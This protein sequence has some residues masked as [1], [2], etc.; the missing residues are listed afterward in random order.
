MSYE[1]INKL[2]EASFRGVSFL[3]KNSNI[4][5]GQKT[6]TYQ[7]PNSD[8]TEVEYLGL[9]Q[10]QF[11]L[12]IYIYGDD[13]LD[14]IKRLKLA[15]SQGRDGQLIH[16]YLGTQNVS[17]VNASLVVNDI[18]LGFARFS[19][20]FQESTPQSSPLV[21]LN[22]K[23]S[24]LRAIDSAIEKVEDTFDNV[25]TTYSFNALY[26]ATKLDAVADTFDNALG[27]TYK[28]TDKANESSY[29]ISQFKDNI[30]TYALAPLEL[31]SSLTSLFS[32]FNFIASDNKEQLRI[33]KSFYDF[34]DEDRAIALTTLEREERSN[35]LNI[36]NNAMKANSLIYAYGTASDINYTN[37]AELD[38]IRDE[39][40][41]QY[42]SIK[43]SLDDSVLKS[44]EIV[45][46]LT[47][48]YLDNL[49]VANVITVDV[50]ETSAVL[51]SFW[52][53]GDQSQYDNIV[54]LNDFIDPAF[55]SGEV[56]V[57][58]G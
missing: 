4:I 39:I 55:M 16:P 15:L 52:Y 3:V 58:N 51:L 8:K 48:E 2:R 19:V 20:T 57:L 1:L 36:I 47:L 10:D 49:D 26:T 24:I 46:K 56:K 12:D 33:W 23:P 44:L 27:L 7:Y 41:E 18:E 42:Q 22:T 5:F 25:T 30:N 43:E 53:Y 50:K 31:A 21:S 14:K 29:Q 32:E 38:L 37:D 34:G 17:V 28:I 11:N 35:T 13:V 40:E 9:S 45:R 54:Q 6:V